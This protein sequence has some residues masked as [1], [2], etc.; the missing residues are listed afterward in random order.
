M[1]PLDLS[2]ASAREEPRDEDVEM[3]ILERAASPRYRLPTPPRELDLELPVLEDRASVRDRPPTPWPEP[4]YT[5]SQSPRSD[6]GLPDLVRNASPPASPTN[7][8]RNTSPPASP[9][10]SFE[11]PLQTNEVSSTEEGHTPDTQYNCAT[12]N[13]ELSVSIN[14]C[15]IILI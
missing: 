1:F 11:L 15:I 12:L 2:A 10:S 8:I 6:I 5:P 7:V 4:I 13:M 14:H 9:T 3:P